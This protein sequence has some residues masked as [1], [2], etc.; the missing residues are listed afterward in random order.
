MGFF[1]LFRKEDERKDV[2]R[3]VFY[4]KS[5]GDAI[6]SDIGGR[7]GTSIVAQVQPKLVNNHSYNFIDAFF[8]G[9]LLPLNVDYN[10]HMGYFVEDPNNGGILKTTFKNIPDCLDFISNPPQIPSAYNHNRTSP[11]VNVRISK[12]PVSKCV[13]P[14]LRNSDELFFPTLLSSGISPIFINSRYEVCKSNGYFYFTQEDLNT[15]NY[16]YSSYDHQIGGI[17]IFYGFIITDSN[18]NVI[19]RHFEMLNSMDKQKINTISKVDGLYDDSENGVRYIKNSF[20]GK[21][22]EDYSVFNL[23]RSHSYV[24]YL[25]HKF[26]I[27][28]KEELVTK[29]L[30]EV[31]DNMKS[32]RIRINRDNKLSS[33]GI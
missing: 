30:S 11:R 7:E 10:I 32:D 27:F 15:P 17:K 4:Y 23:P 18:D 14:M 5:P 22:S 29:N 1:D 28:R 13:L 33:L 2:E 25:D 16:N 9:N 24:S 20:F 31:I 6:K 8:I 12:I 21:N 26:F 19:D 3:T